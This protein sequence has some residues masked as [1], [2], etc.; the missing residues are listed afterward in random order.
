MIVLPNKFSKCPYYGGITQKGNRFFIK[1][2]ENHTLSY[3]TKETA[4]YK[5]TKHCMDS[6][7]E[8]RSFLFRQLEEMGLKPTS[9]WGTEDLKSK[10]LEQTEVNVNMSELMINRT[11]E[12][13]AAEINNIKDQTRKMV[14]YNSI[15]IGR[16]LLEA[17]SMLEHGEWGNWLEEKVD[18]SQ[19][20][21]NNL[22]KIFKEYGSEQITLLGDNAK[23]QALGNL[24]YTQA[25]ALLGVPEEDRE[26]FIKDHDIESMSTRELQQAI[27]ERDEALEK[28]KNAKQVAEEKNNEALK[29]L[30]E[31]QKAEADARVS[32]RC[33]RETQADVKML[34]ESLQKERENSKNEVDRLTK[35]LEDAKSSGDDDQIVKLQCEVA[36]A[37]AALK[38]AEQKIENLECQLKEK[39][40]EVAAATIVEKIPEEVEKELQELRKKANQQNDT[41]I[42]FSVYF[43][44]LVK[45]FQK[46]LST[47]EEI[48]QTDLE[49]HER[50][51]NAVA[52]LINKMSER[53]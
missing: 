3:Q 39:P 47:L 8:C 31:K 34:Q 38:S 25:V 22:M 45:G 46:L 14:L 2:G 21:A 7:S 35:S 36:A 26:A 29:L 51:K 49:S 11:P 6:M 15:E 18:Y 16:R 12:L 48:G 24:S 17:K 43:D 52:G 53:L 44:E 28:L 30:E 19:S 13:I 37:D 42:K 10:Y 32:E 33:L 9:E 20:T 40:I 27:K 4:D 50:Y 5:A 23:S 1:C 41:T